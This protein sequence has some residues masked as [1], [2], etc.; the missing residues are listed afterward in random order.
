MEGYVYHTGAYVC[1][2]GW[3][4]LQCQRGI[5][6]WC[7]YI[8]LH[9]TAF[10]FGFSVLTLFVY[11]IDVAPTQLPTPTTTQ[12]TATTTTTETTTAAAVTTAP[13]TTPAG[14]VCNPIC[15]NGGTC[16]NQH[17]CLSRGMERVILPDKYKNNLIKELPPHKLW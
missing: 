7:I 16:W 15:L 5:T 2:N 4:G 6:I 13:P 10:S 9:A 14:P 12:T 17:L 8:G 1:P 11:T 3:T